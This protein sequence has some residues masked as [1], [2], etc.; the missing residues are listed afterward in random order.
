M[1]ASCCAEHR[2][3]IPQLKPKRMLDLNRWRVNLHSSNPNPVSKTC[4]WNPRDV[5]PHCYCGREGGGGVAPF[6]AAAFDSDRG[7]WRHCLH[8]SSPVNMLPALDITVRPSSAILFIDSPLHRACIYIVVSSTVQLYPLYSGRV[9]GFGLEVGHTQILNPLYVIHHRDLLINSKLVH[10]INNALRAW[11]ENEWPV[12]F[13][14][15]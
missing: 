13:Y 15:F 1:F 9:L 5:H 10:I 3:N 2:V 11:S 8:L 14:V 4:H 12:N 7:Q 6:R